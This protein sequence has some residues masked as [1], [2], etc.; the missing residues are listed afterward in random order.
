MNRNAS[1]I[2][3]LPHF[4]RIKMQAQAEYPG[5]AQGRRNQGILGEAAR[6]IDEAMNLLQKVDVRE[7]AFSRGL[8][9]KYP[10][11]DGPIAALR[12]LA[13]H[14]TNVEEAAVNRSEASAEYARAREYWSKGPAPENDVLFHSKLLAWLL[15]T[16]IHI[17][18]VVES[19]RASSLPEE[20]VDHFVDRAVRRAGLDGDNDSELTRLWRLE[21]PDGGDNKNWFADL[22]AVSR[23]KTDV[24]KK[25]D[26]HRGEFRADV[27]D[28]LRGLIRSLSPDG[29]EAES[30]QRALENLETIP[31]EEEA[32]LIKQ[33]LTA[34]ELTCSESGI[35]DVK[36][37][38]ARLL[39]LGA[40]S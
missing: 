32:T 12:G 40:G 14:L 16:L 7:R 21:R 30:A 29:P 18:I 15:R 25:I 11:V 23:R 8:Q 6:L 27:R 5:I 36:D 4:R 3:K 28:T 9:I 37:L 33:W 31:A 35:L 34:K 22:R 38:I 19:Q 39:G 20:G 26:K 2:D 1:T 10:K 24:A 13:V 17:Q